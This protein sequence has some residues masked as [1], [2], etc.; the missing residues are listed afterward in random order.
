[1]TN[2]PEYMHEPFL[3]LDK[4]I[5]DDTDIKLENIVLKDWETMKQLLI[6]ERADIEKIDWENISFSVKVCL[7][8]DF[9]DKEAMK[10]EILDDANTQAS[11]K[12]YSN[13]SNMYFSYPLSKRKI[14]EDFHETHQTVYTWEG[15]VDL[16]SY[17][18]SGDLLLEP[19]LVGKVPE[20]S[21]SFLNIGG[22]EGFK[23]TNGLKLKFQSKDI[24]GGSAPK[25]IIMSFSEQVTEGTDVSD[26]ITKRVKNYPYFIHLDPKKFDEPVLFINS[27][28]AEN[29]KLHGDYSKQTFSKY[30]DLSK[31]AF[32]GHYLFA[33]EN[34]INYGIRLV[35]TENEEDIPSYYKN[36]MT[37]LARKFV[38][39]S[40]EKGPDNSY[41]EFV[42]QLRDD[43]DCYD[44]TNWLINE[45]DMKKTIEN[46]VQKHD[47]LDFI[48]KINV[49]E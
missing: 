37:K 49:Q 14:N 27:D 1:M 2:W 17:V 40:K 21:D 23:T 18:F 43:R 34:I 48:K 20:L 13:E 7:I 38:S 24:I 3:I 11:L 47:S 30:Y 31:Y 33:W 6:N 19:S 25:I 12:V 16:S 46:V 39:N 10:F 22:G 4:L 9:P 41:R 8:A 28:V 36:L 44:L 26:I 32:H 5:V 29:N 42:S 45:L 35:T 15:K